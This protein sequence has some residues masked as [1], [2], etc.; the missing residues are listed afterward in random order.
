MPGYLK[1]LTDAPLFAEAKS[2]LRARL[3]ETAAAKAKAR[4]HREAAVRGIATPT[5]AETVAA[6]RARLADRARRHGWPKRKGDLH[7]FVAFRHFDWEE[8]LIDAFKPF[9][10]VTVF[11]WSSQGFN[12]EAG[13]WPERRPHMNR[14]MLEAFEAANARRPVDV[15]VGYL[16]GFTTMPQTVDAMTRAGAA[17]FNFSYD[18][19]LDT[20]DPLPDGVIR[21]PTGLAPNV[22]LSLTHDPDGI[23]KYVIRGG[24]AHFHPEAAEP[25]IHHPHDVPFKYDVSF[26]GGMY[27]ARPGFIDKLKKSGVDV[28]AFGRGW[29]AGTLTLDQMVE[30]FSLSRINLGF[31]GIGHSLKL[32]CLK[33][34][35]FEIPMAGGLYLTQHNPE[36]DLVFEVGT[37][38]VT[39][40]DVADCV[41]KIKALLADD[42]RSAAIRAAGRA[43]CLTD[44]SYEARWT[45]VFEM[46]GVLE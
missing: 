39:Y 7:V 42:P 12:Q 9:G 8:V 2:R 6:L 15:V 20:D 3:Q 21:G 43:R 23:L 45:K 5:T 25:H 29:P 44:H 19:K 37:E 11:E 14:A 27:G 24:L 30:M 31:G 32:M 18:D 22:D 38:I 35:D 46:A 41:A 1:T 10:E 17:V 33:G 36:L 26:V 4:I 40:T 16:S 28:V 34:R 13:D